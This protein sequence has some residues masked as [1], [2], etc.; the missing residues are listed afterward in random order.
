VTQVERQRVLAAV[1]RQEV[2]RLARDHGREL[3]HRVALERLDLD[4]ARAA[5]GEQLGTER[6]GDE[7]AELD[8]L[9]AGER[10]GVVHEALA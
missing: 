8:H 5:L 6:D 4:D 2:A 10:T 7:L 1:A 9:D 3:A